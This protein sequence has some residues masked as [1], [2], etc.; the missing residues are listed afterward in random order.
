MI[1]QADILLY[2][3]QFQAIQFFGV[4]LSCKGWLQ[5]L[6]RVIIAAITN[7]VHSEGLPFSVVDKPTFREMLHGAHFA[8]AKYYIPDHKSVSGNLSD[9]TYE[10]CF[11]HQ[12]LQ[13][14]NQVLR[15]T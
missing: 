5:G 10:T 13:K 14:L 3:L 7:F 2:T 8:P 11:A 12:N 9:I 15:G 4:P 1:F 6:A